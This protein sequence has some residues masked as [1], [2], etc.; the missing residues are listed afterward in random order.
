MHSALQHGPRPLPLFLKLANDVLAGNESQLRALLQA[1]KR[2]Q[3]APR[4][5]KQKL[6]TTILES[7]RVK[8]RMSRYSKALPQNYRPDIVFV[9]SPI[10][11]PD[12]LDMH[13]DMSL[14]AFL[15]QAGHSPSLVDWG[16][17]ARANRAESV[18]NFVAHYLIDLL[19]QISRPVHLVGY[20]LGGLVALAAAQH[21]AVKSLT[22]IASPW[23]FSAYAQDRRDK[24]EV[25]WQRSVP[26]CDNL[27]MVPMEVFQQAFWALDP[28]RVT[29]KYL[30]FASFP[31]NSAQQQKFIAIEDWANGGEALPFAMG[32][33]IFLDFYRDNLPGRGHWKLQGKIMSPEDLNCPTLEI[34][35]STDQIVP[36]SSSPN[37]AN[38][39]V[40]DSGHVGMVVGGSARKNLWARLDDWFIENR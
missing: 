1:V 35:S 20:C 2:Y 5:F 19:S 31:D 9:P 7:G 24:M 8:L 36:L 13:A 10:N 16:H 30:K 25:L 14:M 22:L 27:G 40:L 26:L 37:F 23:D 12:I 32:R 15:E 38:R 18:D 6:G 17:T 34:A 3:H 4:A 11:A 28:A 29:E 21:F 39:L 33:Q